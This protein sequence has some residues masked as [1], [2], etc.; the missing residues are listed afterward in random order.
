M[1][2]IHFGAYTS[3]HHLTIVCY[4]NAFNIFDKLDASYKDLAGRLIASLKEEIGD[5][6]FDKYCNEITADE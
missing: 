5:A 2:P 3:F 6:L 1:G 4:R